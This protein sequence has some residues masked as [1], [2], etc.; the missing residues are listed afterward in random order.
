MKKTNACMN[1]LMLRMYR[2]VLKV[3]LIH[4]ITDYFNKAK[5]IKMKTNQNLVRLSR[6]YYLTAKK[7]HKIMER[8]VVQRVEEIA[9]KFPHN[10]AIIQEDTMEQISFGELMSRAKLLNE[11]LVHAIV[12]S[13]MNLVV[14]LESENMNPLISI[15]MDRGIGIIVG[16][17]AILKAGAAYVPVDPTFPKSRQEYIIEHS[18]STIVVVDS[19]NFSNLKEMSANMDSMPLIIV[20]DTNTGLIDTQKT[21][22]KLYQNISQSKNCLASGLASGDQLQYILYTSGSTGKPKGVMVKNKGVLNCVEFFTQELKM[23]P[24]DKVLGLTT[25]C[26]DISVLET[27]M[28]LTSGA[29]L[30]IASM[31]TQKNPYKIIKLL[32]KLK[33]TVM[34]ATPTTYEMMISTGTWSGSNDITFLVGGEAF[35]PTISCL[36]TNCKALYNVYGPT[37]TTIWSSYYKFPAIKN[38]SQLPLTCPIG[39]P[40][41]NT[42]FYIVDEQFNEVDEGEEGE[43]LIGGTGVAAGYLHA[44]DLTKARF[45]NLP[46]LDSTGDKV[47]RTG[48]V[49]KKLKN[50]LNEVDCIIL[51]DQKKVENFVFV[52]RIDDQVKVNGY[53]Y[54]FFFL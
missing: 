20:I 22:I 1:Y 32:D 51:L 33:I 6:V 25:Y 27:F 19:V 28:P 15:M 18:K 39:I 43:L 38:D 21:S 5:Q 16:M 14:D 45:V 4:S 7:E 54:N 2:K 40:I 50:E 10:I 41:S 17:L 3:L 29:T 12:L 52:R 24:S 8:I 48:D 49:V 42:Q 37:E 11:I 30:V 9:V 31:K 35:R 34:Q 36:A 53:R 13:A 46:K 26:F 47:Y 23:N 44:N